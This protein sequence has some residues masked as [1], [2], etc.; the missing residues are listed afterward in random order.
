MN[1]K[2]EQTQFFHSVPIGVT[3]RQRGVYVGQMKNWQLK[4]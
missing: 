1:E 2:N 3:L 4:M